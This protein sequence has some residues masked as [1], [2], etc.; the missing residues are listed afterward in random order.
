VALDVVA[1]QLDWSLGSFQ[2]GALERE[3]E[4]AAEKIV[5][6]LGPDGLPYRRGGGTRKSNAA[7]GA[8]GLL[9]VAS[10]NLPVGERT[11]FGSAAA[12]RLLG[13]DDATPGVVPASPG[14]GP[15][16]ISAV[17]APFRPV[18]VNG[19]VLLWGENPNSI[20][21]W[22]G[23]RRASGSGYSTGTA[24]STHGS[25]TVT[26]IGTAWLANLQPGDTFSTG[27][28]QGVVASVESDTSLTLVEPY[29]G[30]TATQGYSAAGALVSIP[31]LLSA[32]YGSRIQASIANRWVV[33]SGNTVR[34]TPQAL[35]PQYVVE[36]QEDDYHPFPEAVLGL[37]V[38]RDVLVVFTQGGVYAVSNMG[39]DL[40]D[41]AGN[42]QQRAELVNSGVV[43]W[44]HPG[45]ASWEGTLI[46]P[47]LDNIW[48]MDNLGAPTPIGDRILDTYL[49]YVRAGYKP[50][51]A[52][53]IY[54]QYVLP[55]LDAANNSVATLACRLIPTHSDTAMGWT[56]LEGSD[57]QVAAVATRSSSNPSLLLGAS[58]QATSRV[59]DLSKFFQPSGA[60]KNDADGTTP[61]FQVTTT[62][63][64]TGGMQ[65]NF[66]H[67]VRLQY[68]LT[69][70][71]ADNPTIAAEV[72]VDGGGWTALT[73]TAAESSQG[74][75]RWRVNRHAKNV[76]FRFTVA[77]PSA[78]CNIES[79][80]V[81][82]RHSGR[83][84]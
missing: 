42:P 67:H 83:Q 60:V 43:A 33:A 59:L 74:E 39:F 10:L 64:P 23:S 41:A 79:V 73:G 2:S 63:Y 17:G 30:V 56:F 71:A 32:V 9:W 4:N 22:A 54:G 53:V 50:G 48:L 44:G 15:Y 47:A 84:S 12:I 65:S 8:A 76:R 61:S 75:K 55:I 51:V 19:W 80:E 27:G 58:R 6:L 29:F 82:V 35:L 16:A 28:V 34:F 66:V 31:T 18:I 69:D 3:P 78:S 81:L 11:I 25:K 46:V 36:F 68:T 45:I 5:G 26:G 77:L 37:G 70:A 72:S 13:N 62:D 57:A 20:H 52:D 49:G 24:T 38:L 7:L 21:W 1:Q 14:G 40:T